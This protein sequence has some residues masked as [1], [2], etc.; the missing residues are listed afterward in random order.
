MPLFVFVLLLVFGLLLLGF[1]CACITDHPV[2]AIERALA[3]IPA[4]PPLVEVWSVNAI[5][6]MAL[7]LL[8]GRRARPVA[9]PSPA[10]LQRFL[11]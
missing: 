2:Q 11:L 10:G 1:A 7:S 6:L 9:R 3:A 8:V 5:A 4:L